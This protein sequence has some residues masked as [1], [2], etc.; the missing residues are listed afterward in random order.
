MSYV[1]RFPGGTS[2]F[3]STGNGSKSVRASCGAVRA[4]SF[5]TATE[6]TTID[7]PPIVLFS[8]HIKPTM[9]ALSVWKGCAAQVV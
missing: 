3:R 6:D 5:H 8:R 1:G 7:S 9:S 2:P 4:S